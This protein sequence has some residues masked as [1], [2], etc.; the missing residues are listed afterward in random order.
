[1]SDA[2]RNPKHRKIMARAFIAAAGLA[3]CAGVLFAGIEGFRIFQEGRSA[4][5]R[6]QEA[7][8]ESSQKANREVR[9]EI[10]QV[11][12][13]TP[14]EL[15]MI[16]IVTS[17]R[18]VQ[19]NGAGDSER[20]SVQGFYSNGNSGELEEV[21]GATVSYAS[22]DSAV[23]RVDARGA[24]T[25][26]KAG[27]ADVVVSYGKFESTVPIFVWGPVRRIP[28][29]DQARLLEVSDDGS[30]VVLN[31]V[32]VKMKPGY[33]PE[34]AQQLA[35]SIGGGVVFEFRTFPGYVVDFDARTRN[36]LDHALA[37]LRADHRVAVAYP[38]MTMPSSQGPTNE[39][40]A[41][42]LHIDISAYLS[43]GIVGAWD[44][45]NKMGPTVFSP[46]GIAVID[47]DFPGPQSHP[48]EHLKYPVM[49]PEFGSE[50][51]VE[52][53]VSPGYHDRE[54]HGAAVTSI[55]A[56]RNNIP[57][58]RNESFSGVVSSVKGLPY[59]IVVYGTGHKFGRV[60]GER[61]KLSSITTALQNINAL[62]QIEPYS[63]QVHVVNISIKLPCSSCA[64]EDEIADLIR[65]MPGITFVVGA[66]N[67][68]KDI[69]ERNR[70]LASPNVITV[71]GLSGNSRHPDSNHGPAITLGAPYNVWAVRLQNEDGYGFKSGTSYST[72][73]VTGTVALLKAVDHS[74]SPTEIKV[75]LWDKGVTI[76]VCNS[77][78]T[79]CLEKDQTQ[80]KKLNAEAA[81]KEAIKQSANGIIVKPSPTALPSVSRPTFTPPAVGSRVQDSPTQYDKP[82]DVEV[83]KAVNQ[84]LNR[85]FVLFF[86]PVNTSTCHKPELEQKY[87]RHMEPVLAEIDDFI[88]G[89]L[90]RMRA[91]EDLNALFDSYEAELAQACDPRSDDNIG[92][93]TDE[94]V[95]LNAVAVA[96]KGAMI[97]HGIRSCPQRELFEKYVTLFR[98]YGPVLQGRLDNRE[99]I[100]SLIEYDRILVDYGDAS[101]EDCGSQPGHFGSGASP[102]APPTGRRGVGKGT[103]W[104]LELSDAFFDNLLCGAAEE[105]EQKKR[106]FR[107]SLPV[108]QGSGS[109]GMHVILPVDDPQLNVYDENLLSACY[110]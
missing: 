101:V 84:V 70:I 104:E 10:L 55:L 29:L 107:R 105:I 13:E 81:L 47:M 17:P 59:S 94:D 54:H 43:T 25:G 42:S 2:L 7:V 51:R 69:G 88:S 23:A 30:A 67:D 95:Y 48:E 71:G 83:S 44:E 39:T 1:M 96:K 9:Q 87:I 5:E 41:N 108:V 86:D 106:L 56:A 36:D 8:Q 18:I 79:P 46:V 37:V 78:D 50:I 40:M 73:L 38:D 91:A 53:L 90:A 92:S 16:G 100:R 89:N 3:L 26:V 24:V 57:P 77:N 61:P 85:Y 75:L 45:I 76:N 4:F 82:T 74:L 21:P 103:P 34:D 27:G 97:I 22:S 20:L 66:G 102:N 33:V 64:Y 65:S 19:L 14:H 32:M 28:V 63:R 62:E 6:V 12:Q 93:P 99:R 98:Q 49:I 31:R 109:T 80:W 52:D 110:R 15:R 35:S 72:P 11:S 58:V 60:L 68:N